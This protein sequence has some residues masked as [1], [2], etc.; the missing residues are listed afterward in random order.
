MKANVRAQV[1]MHL[2]NGFGLAAPEILQA[3]FILIGVA[4]AS[5]TQDGIAAG[6]ILGIYLFVPAALSPVQQIIGFVGSIRMSWPSVARVGGL[7]DL[8]MAPLVTETLPEAGPE[9]VSVTLENV[10]FSYRGVAS[11]SSRD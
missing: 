3:G 5:L 11:R 4:I 2:A 10:T 7:L 1:R 6:A 9:P 8:D